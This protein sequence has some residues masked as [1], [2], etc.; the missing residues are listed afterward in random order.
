MRSLVAAAGVSAGRWARLA[1]TIVAVLAAAAAA[2]LLEDVVPVWGGMGHVDQNHSDLGRQLLQVDYNQQKPLWERNGQR[3]TAGNRPEDSMLWKNRFRLYDLYGRWQIDP[4]Y[5]APPAGTKQ[6]TA[7]SLVKKE[8]LEPLNEAINRDFE[9]NFWYG[10][11]LPGGGHAWSVPRRP[12]IRQSVPYTCDTNPFDECPTP[13][14]RAKCEKDGC[15]YGYKLSTPII[16]PDGGDFQSNV[17]VAIE[18][19]SARAMPSKLPSRPNFPIT[20][21]QNGLCKRKCRNK[22]TFPACLD[23]L[24]PMRSVSA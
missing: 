22:P 5:R 11:S 7:D 24:C 21:F 20:T 4:D 10:E 19:P 1:V 16:T 8:D 14:N 3:F 18:V 9:A 15:A 12:W 17:M 13:K 23:Q 2:E 6:G